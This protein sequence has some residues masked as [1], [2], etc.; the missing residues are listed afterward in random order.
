MFRN[1]VHDL[2]RHGTGAVIHCGDDLAVHLIGTIT[3]TATVE[4]K[5][6]TN[7]RSTKRHVYCLALW[8]AYVTGYGDP[9]PDMY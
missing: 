1:T 3:T 5:D 6:G 7:S 9:D 2:V 4:Q 8:L